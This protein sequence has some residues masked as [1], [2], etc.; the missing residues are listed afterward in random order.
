MVKST[1]DRGR[2]VGLGL[3]LATAIISGF[4]VFING[5]G[6]T[7]WI[8]I[9]DATTYTTL[10]NLVA[11]VVLLVVA[12]A[13]TMRSST[14]GL[15]RP[16]SSRQVVGLSAVA[17]LGG[18]AAFALFFEGLSR[19]SSAQA[20]FIHKTLV[21][22]VA[23][24]A[25]GLLRESIRPGHVAAIG[26]LVV[27]QFVLIGGVG[28]VVFGVGEMM[29]LGATLLWSIEVVIAKRLLADLSSL[30]VGVARMVGGVVILVVYGILFGG[31]GTIGALTWSHVGWI[32]ATGLVL[33]GYVGSWYAALSLAPAVD[34]TAILVGGA[35][36]TA[37]LRAITDG[38]PIAAPAGLVLLVL[39]VGLSVVAA[40]G[41]RSRRVAAD[42]S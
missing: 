21:V 32:L 14:R 26:L 1:T 28:D 7:R 18:A 5:F 17:V 34:V 40:R 12:G 8:E 4:A 36:V 35:V 11:G 6:V 42:P 22:W 16:T 37:M 10:K 41:R 24:L 29:I 19:A 20:A 38:T 27:G 31:L 25:V 9:T 23:I 3:A 13:L 33:A 30:T 39:G 15:T 2:R